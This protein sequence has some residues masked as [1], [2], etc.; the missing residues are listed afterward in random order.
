MVTLM[1]TSVSSVS[2]GALQS[3]SSPAVKSSPVKSRVSSSHVKVKRSSVTGQRSRVRVRVQGPRLG[4]CQGCRRQRV[5]GRR[6][7]APRSQVARVHGSRRQGRTAPGPGSKYPRAQGHRGSRI[8][9]VHAVNGL[10]GT[11][12]S[13]E[14]QG[15]PS[16]PELPR[17]Q[18]GPPEV[19]PRQPRVQGL[20]A[21]PGLRRSR[22]A[23]RDSGSRGEAQA[24]RRATSS[25][26]PRT[27]PPRS[28]RHTRGA[29][30]AAREGATGAL[31]KT[32]SHARVPTSFPSQLDRGRTQRLTTCGSQS[33]STRL[34]EPP[35]RD[36]KPSPRRAH[37]GSQSSPPQQPADLKPAPRK[38]RRH[39]ESILTHATDMTTAATRPE[40]GDTAD[41]PAAATAESHDKSLGSTSP[42]R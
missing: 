10:Q 42:R 32:R 14:Y 12:A 19:A 7:Q 6:R 9:G 29:H 41:T 38:P 17:G 27:R 13:H 15:A 31:D 23:R 20:R 30:Q 34:L 8:Q 22:R 16:V 24:D 26:S 2:S 1:L 39:K 21:S 28:T 18:A 35:K 5:H 25:R 11:S 33:A 40:R 36:Y 37:S 3:G 4:A